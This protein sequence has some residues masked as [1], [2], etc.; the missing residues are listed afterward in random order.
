MHD[1]ADDPPI[2]HPLDTSYIGRQMQFDP[3]PLF[4]AQP[5][6]VPAHDPHPPNESGRYGIRIVLP[7]QQ[8]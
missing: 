3:I 1:P 8:N 7:P 2:V 6:Q 5:K 4:I